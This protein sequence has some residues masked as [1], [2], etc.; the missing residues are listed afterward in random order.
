MGSRLGQ[1]ILWHM[2]ENDDLYST[3]Y[4]YT[5]DKPGFGGRQSL[6]SGKDLF[7]SSMQSVTTMSKLL[8]DSYDP[9][10]SLFSP[11]PKLAVIIF[12]LIV[13]KGTLLEAYYDPTKEQICIEEANHVRIHILHHDLP[14][15]SE[16]A[17]G[18]RAE[19]LCLERNEV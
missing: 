6:T 17:G 19:G 3:S 9:F 2:A 12:P 18:H 8:V 5:P 13:I 11:L 15:E 16:G 4:F 1:A 10:P 7:Y 14:A